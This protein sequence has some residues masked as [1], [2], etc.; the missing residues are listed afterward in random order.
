[1][2]V[3][4][5]TLDAAGKLVPSLNQAPDRAA[6][7]YPP[8]SRFPG[9]DLLPHGYRRLVEHV[10]GIYLNDDGSTAILPW[11]YGRVGCRDGYDQVTFAVCPLHW[12]LRAWRRRYLGEQLLLSLNIMDL[13]EEGGMFASA[14]FVTPWRPRS[15]PRRPGTVLEQL[16]SFWRVYVTRRGWCP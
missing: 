10:D 6:P 4:R 3:E 1:M 11:Y 9:Y 7:N 14:Y 15:T 2:N 12:I 16:R 5:W 13:T 8:G